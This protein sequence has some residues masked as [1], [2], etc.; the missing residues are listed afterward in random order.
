MSQIENSISSI[1]L[2]DKSVLLR[3][4]F[5]VPLKGSELLDDERLIR[6]LPTINFIA[7]N[8]KSLKIISHLGRPEE[9]GL[10]QDKFSLKPVA[11]KLA[12]L[13]GKEVNLVNSLKELKSLKNISMLENI[14]FYKGEKQNEDKLSKA[15]AE[16]ADVFV[17][18]A[19]GT[20]HRKQA[21]TFGVTKFVKEACVGLLVEEELKALEKIID[22]PEK[23][24]LGIIGGSK[25][26]TKMKV[27]ESLTRH[28]D[29]LIIGGALAN[30]CLKALGKNIGKSLYEKDFIE[31][32]KTIIKNKKIL[33]PSY[34]VVTKGRDA[35]LEEK[36]IDDVEDDDIIFDI[37]QSSIEDFSQY[38][39][40]AKTII[41]N[42]PMGYFE[43]E[44]FAKGTA[45]IALKISESTG[46]S[47]IGGGETLASFSNLNMMDCVDYA[48]TAGGAFL[49]YIELGTLPCIEV[50]K[51]K[52]MGT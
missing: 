35:N 44:R 26:S 16:T 52:N 12:E 1:D 21:S 33:L 34:V 15:L 51:N 24:I 46:Y 5:N 37:G 17:M 20:A 22:S 4:D 25:I 36:H 19:F 32:A 48:S 8:A 3:V 38:I 7:E 31:L 49:E 23:P 41:W 28:V 29:H 39:N 42:G 10:V 11:K 40:S 2:T 27:L 50:I 13:L 18:D 30:T 45:G 14:R 47:I 43:E 6:A 9:T